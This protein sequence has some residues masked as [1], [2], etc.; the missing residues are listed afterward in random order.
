MDTAELVSGYRRY[1][2][3]MT[4]ADIAADLP[5]SITQQLIQSL[6]QSDRERLQAVLSYP[7]IVRADL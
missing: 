6:S 2:D 3:W 5:E 7:K 1:A 4:L